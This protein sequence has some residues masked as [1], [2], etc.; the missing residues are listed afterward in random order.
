MTQIRQR[1]ILATIVIGLTAT[2]VRRHCA[3]AKP[4]DARVRHRAIN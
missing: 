4:C 2:L 1:I 3:R